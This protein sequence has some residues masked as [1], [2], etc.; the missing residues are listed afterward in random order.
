MRRPSGESGASLLI[1][2]VFMAFI[3]VVSLSLLDLNAASFSATDSV[4]SARQ[5]NNAADAAV[6]LGIRRVVTDLTA[7]LGT[8]AGPACD[9]TIGPI[10]GVFP[11]IRCQPDGGAGSSPAGRPANAVLALAGA[12][13]FTGNAPVLI[14]GNV[15]ATGPLTTGQTKS[16]V[17]VAGTVTALGGGDCADAVK[18]IATARYCSAPAPTAAQGADPAWSP[19]STTF[20]PGGVVS[21]TSTPGGVAVA[22]F[23]AGKYTVNPA[24]LLTGTA[25]ANRDVLYF[26]SG[27]YYF[28]DVVFDTG[29]YNV[30]LGTAGSWLTTNIAL[31]ADRLCDGAG[32]GGQ[33]LFG[34]STTLNVPNEFTNLSLCAGAATATQPAIA[35]YGARSGS[36]LK[37]LSSAL[38]FKTG[39]KPSVFIDG[40]IY[41]PTAALDL[42]LHN[43]NQTYLSGGIVASALTFDIN[44]SRTQFGS[45][46]SLPPC[47][48]SSPC[49][50]N[51]RVVLTASIGGTDRI[52][53]VVQFDDS[54]GATPASTYTVESWNVLR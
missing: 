30:V 18:V 40:T 31:P 37:P 36:G 19:R 44:A 24:S 12:V 45:P 28:E 41:T 46:I 27:N 52:R 23:A 33:F 50:S 51:R 47:S 16:I 20:G 11:R 5:N 14:G 21:C 53:A 4:R 7:T 43:R 32:Q 17:T 38:A 26:P 42:Q 15:F 3:A 48:P 10:N 8:S 6:E 54:A 2:L 49:Q 29:N 13:D 22:T 25:C 35:V 39:K 34:G 9:F 1:V